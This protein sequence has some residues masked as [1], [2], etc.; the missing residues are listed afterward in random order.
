VQRLGRIFGT[1]IAAAAIAGAFS[2]GAP[3]ITAARSDAF[4]LSRL[5]AVKLDPRSRSKAIYALTVGRQ[6]SLDA[7]LARR[8]ARTRTAFLRAPRRR[9]QQALFLA[10]SSAGPAPLCQGRPA[11]IRGT[12]GDD[13][14]YGTPGRDVIVGLAGNDEIHGLGQGDIICGGAGDDLVFGGAGDDSVTGGDGHDLLDGGL[15]NDTLD[16]GAGQFDGAAFFD[17][18]GPVTASLATGTATGQGSDTFTNMEELHGG[19]YTDTFTGDSERNGLFGN[20]GN[21]SLGGGLGDDYLSG[22]LGD[23]F[24]DGG[25]GNDTITFWDATGPVMASLVSNSSSGEGSDT[26]T[27]AES[28][29]GGSYGDTLIGNSGDNFI[30]GGDGNDSLSGGDGNDFLDGGSGD[31]TMDGGPGQFDAAAFFDETGPVTA[32]LATGTATGQGSDTFTNI[33]ALH[34]GDFSDTFTGNDSD[35]GL[36]GNG[37]DDTISGGGG[38]DILNGGEG[39]DT[40]NG[41][42][43]NDF[44]DAGSGDDTLDGGP[45]DFDSAAFFDANGPITA[46]LAT[47]SSTGDGVDTFINVEQLAGGPYADTLS[48]WAGPTVGWLFGNGGDDTLTGG[49]GDE[50]LFGQD[51]NDTL[52]GGDGRD[53]V[54]GGPG[55]DTMDGGAGFDAAAFFDENGPVTASLVTGT[56]TGQ[57]NDTFT[58]VE[59]LH[60]GDFSDTFAGGAG[61]DEF[62]GNGG[63]DTINAG[64]GND[65]ANGGS[66]DDTLNGEGGNDYLDG[67]EGYDTLDGGP[68]SNTCVNGE[69]LANC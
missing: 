8:A 4:A 64:D 36:F 54:D 60:G 2:G 20:G 22:G 67:A 24:S 27:N 11:T 28:L 13:L 46:S 19:G 7:R 65:V 61:D 51:G 10:I 44:F 17:E 50:F 69:V 16:G 38:N 12:E 32:S 45:G 42:D 55:N 23:D 58:G 57:G 9:L 34:G 1:G 21:D 35:N 33:E 49:S 15:G 25:P 29:Q 18:T 5:D 68:G 47:G 6:T 52:N 30:S 59:G 63:N 48:G 41:G 62:F 43:G 37:G 3:A 26:F 56:A 39:N 40:L 53:F 31:D 14:I 66:G